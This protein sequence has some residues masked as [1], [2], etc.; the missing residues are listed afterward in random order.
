MDTSQL[1]PI[2]V[3]TALGLLPYKQHKEMVSTLANLPIEGIDQNI[4]ATLNYYVREEDLS[5]A[6]Y[7]ALLVEPTDELQ[8]LLHKVKPP[9]G[10][11]TTPDTIDTAKH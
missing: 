7:I 10:I 3:A 9:S 2:V 11:E 1:P 8:R 4:T 6:T 5:M